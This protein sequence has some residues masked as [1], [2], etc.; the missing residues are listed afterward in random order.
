MMEEHI[1]SISTAMDTLTTDMHV[2]AILCE[3]N[4]VKVNFSN[5]IVITSQDKMMDIQAHLS[6][7]S[8]KVLVTGSRYGNNTTKSFYALLSTTKLARGEGMHNHWYLIL[9][10]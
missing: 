9:L 2:N 1:P 3:M 4:L 10:I 6:T 5:E 7:A 8:Y